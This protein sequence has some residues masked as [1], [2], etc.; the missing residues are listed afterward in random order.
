MSGVFRN[1]D[2]PPPTARRVCTP[3]FGAVGGHTR[4]VERGWGVNSSEDARHSFVLYI[5]KCFVLAAQSNLP[6]VDLLREHGAKVTAAGIN[7][8]CTCIY[9]CSETPSEPFQHSWAMPD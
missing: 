7:L 8:P 2:P 1:I 4:W 6:L 5:C 9:F 3:A